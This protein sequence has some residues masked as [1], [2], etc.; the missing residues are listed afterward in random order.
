MGSHQIVLFFVASV[1]SLYYYYY[2]YSFISNC[3]GIFAIVKLFLLTKVFRFYYFCMCYWLFSYV[4]LYSILPYSR[5]DCDR[6]NKTCFLYFLHFVIFLYILYLL[7][8]LMRSR[9]CCG[10]YCK[11]FNL[12]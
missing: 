7:V 2:R 11:F 6:T 4:V 3:R 12:T 5:R 9:C 8:V 1:S 10:F